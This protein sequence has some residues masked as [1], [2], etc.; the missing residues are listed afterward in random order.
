MQCFA[1]EDATSNVMENIVRGYA[2]SG[3]WHLIAFVS[4]K[5]SLPSLRFRV[6][7]IQPWIYHFQVLFSCFSIYSGFGKGR[8]VGGNY[9]LNPH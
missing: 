1:P 4:G 8:E 6:A 7:E 9:I 5:C 3:V 2:I